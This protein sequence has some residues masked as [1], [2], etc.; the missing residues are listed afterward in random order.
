MTLAHLYHGVS[1]I[2]CHIEEIITHVEI[3]HPMGEIRGILLI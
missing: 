1:I 3:D 2:V